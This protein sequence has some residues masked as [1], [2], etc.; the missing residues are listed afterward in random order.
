MRPNLDM[1]R[2]PCEKYINV[3]IEDRL[4]ILDDDYCVV[5]VVYVVFA[6]VRDLGKIRIYVYTR[7][8]C[9]VHRC[10]VPYMSSPNPTIS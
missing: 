4:L 8:S 5:Y 9:D 1:Q 3:D 2:F 6:F 7:S 10:H